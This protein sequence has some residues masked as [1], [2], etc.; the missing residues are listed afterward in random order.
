MRTVKLF[1]L[2][3][4]YTMGLAGVSKA[5]D[6]KES[7]QQPLLTTTS[8]SGV[9]SKVH[10]A[11]LGVLYIAGMSASVF[12]CNTEKFEPFAVSALVGSVVAWLL[13]GA[14]AVLNRHAK[15]SKPPM[16]PQAEGKKPWYRRD[17]KTASLYLSGLSPLVTLLFFSMIDKM[18]TAESAS[19][20]IDRVFSLGSAVPMAVHLGCLSKAYYQSK[21]NNK[22][23]QPHQK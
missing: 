22:T 23:A 3:L 17:I 19:S 18:R 5:G 6:L 10:A 8:T 20:T 13:V 14:D 4:A 15:T 7:V 11:K 1:V 9:A 16:V 2:V 21:H 12:A